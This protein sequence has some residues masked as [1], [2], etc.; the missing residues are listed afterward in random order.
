MCTTTALNLVSVYTFCLSAMRWFGAA[1]GLDHPPSPD[2]CLC[3][4]EHARGGHGRRPGARHPLRHARRRE[5][6]CV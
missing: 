3:G 5:D 1:R 6:V 4:G 2:D